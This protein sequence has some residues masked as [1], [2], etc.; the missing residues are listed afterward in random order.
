[1]NAVIQGVVQHRVRAELAVGFE[2]GG[3]AAFPG[4]IVRVG[5]RGRLAESEKMFLAPA[6]GMGVNPVVVAQEAVPERERNQ[7]DGVHPERIHPNFIDQVLIDL[8]EL[9]DYLGVLGIDVADMSERVEMLLVQTGKVRDWRCPV[10]DISRKM[11]GIEPVD[12]VE[13]VLHGRR[14]VGIRLQQVESRGCVVGV[15]FAF[16]GVKI[17][18]VIGDGVLDQV[19]PAAVQ[20]MGQAFVI[21]ERAVMRVDFLEMHRP[22]AVP[23]GCLI[24]RAPPLVV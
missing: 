8:L 1:M 18:N 12:H 24:R 9:G 11:F 3:H 13:R 19:H 21:V 2:V 17:A 5:H 6:A 4:V 7:G 10:V 20:F 22:I 15:V 16:V 23:A 14:L